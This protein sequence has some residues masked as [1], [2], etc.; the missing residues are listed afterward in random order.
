MLFGCPY[1]PG[2]SEDQQLAASHLATYS[3]LETANPTGTLQRKGPVSGTRFRPWQGA[4]HHRLPEN[5]EYKTKQNPSFTYRGGSSRPPFNLLRFFIYYNCNG[6]WNFKC[7]RQ[8]VSTSGCGKTVRSSTAQADR[9]GTEPQFLW[10]L[11]SRC[12]YRLFR[13]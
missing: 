7:P 2:T 3:S 5:R 1:L 6:R 4:V 8:T 13:N 12:L 10:T 11:P 9:S